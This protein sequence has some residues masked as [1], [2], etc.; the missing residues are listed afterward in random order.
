MDTID[1][2]SIIRFAS[3]L[4]VIVPL[5]IYLAR[6]Q[7]A[8]RAIHI[9]GL[10]LVVSGAC[11]LAGLMMLQQKEST[12]PL[13]N[14][15]YVLLFA[16][17]TWFYF[18]IFGSG[19]RKAIVLLGLAVYV[20][21]FILITQ[22]VQPFNSYQTLMWLITGIIMMVFSIGYFL[23]SFSRIHQPEFF[24]YSFIWI[25]S[26]V[27][28]YFALNLFLFIL[29]NHVLT[30]ADPM[31]SAMIWSFHNVN[32]ILKNV[33]FAIGIYFYRNS[34]PGI[35]EISKPLDAGVKGY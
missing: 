9:I 35:R 29:A 27:L 28:I 19:N 18:E 24:N 5:A 6:I 21:S 34:P 31:M 11:D 17:L 32:N 30:R 25:N 26:G 20:P 33:L 4:S 1:L 22:F 15:Y 7:Y 12:A 8:S 2:S 16:L 13:F 3:N 14:V 23:N 10:L